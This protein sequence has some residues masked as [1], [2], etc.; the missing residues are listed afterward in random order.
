[1]KLSNPDDVYKLHRFVKDRGIKMKAIQN[2]L[3]AANPERLPNVMFDVTLKDYKNLD[4]IIPLLKKTGYE[5][6][7]IHI[8]WVLTD[9]YIAVQR[10]QTRERIV[11][12]DIVLKTH[13]GAARTMASLIKR[14]LPYNINGSVHVILNNPENIVFFKGPGEGDDNEW[15]IKD[16]TYLTIKESSEDFKKENQIMKQLQDWIVSNTPK[17]LNRANLFDNKMEKDSSKSEGKRLNREE[18]IQM[19]NDYDKF[20]KYLRENHPEEDQSDEDE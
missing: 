20:E 12:D 9:Y 15:V 6:E 8:V 17:T 11:P 18:W 13:E 2:V 19:L 5:N 16:F 7:N 10:N 14:G 1:M 4:K 3:N